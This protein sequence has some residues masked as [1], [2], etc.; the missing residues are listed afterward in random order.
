MAHQIQ[1]TLTPEEAANSEI[2]IPKFAKNAGINVDDIVKFQ[3]TSRSI[4]AR[5]PP[6]KVNMNAKLYTDI[7]DHD[8]II[9]PFAAKDVSKAPEAIIVGAGPAGLFA[10]LTFIEQGIKPVIIERGKRVGER[11]RDVAA[12]STKHY[13][14]PDSNYAFGEGGAGT[15]SDGKLY[16]RSKKRGDI[17]RIYELLYLHGAQEEILYESQPHIGSDVLAQVVVNIRQTI[18]DAGGTILFQQ[19]VTDLIT[20]GEQVTGVKLSD[21]RTMAAAAVVLATGHS[22]RDVYE[23]LQNRG[24]MLEAKGFALGVRLEHPQ[25]LINQIQYHSNEPDPHLPPASYKLVKQVDDRGV[26]SFCMCPGGFIV[27]AATANDQLVVN[28]MSP[29]KRNGTYANSGMVVEL[30]TED[31]PNAEGNPLAGIRYQEQLEKMAFMNGG[32]GQVAPAQG[33]ADFVNNRVSADMPENSYFPGLISSPMHFW[34]PEHVSSRLK[35]AF[36]AFGKKMRGFLTND[37]LVI[38][39]ESRTSSPVRIYRDKEALTSFPYDGLYPTG[40]GAG[41]AGGIVSSALDGVRVARKI[42]ETS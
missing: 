18:L 14:D 42:A 3:I 32:Q 16:T 5:K 33:M 22:A 23:M 24:V 26:Y 25:E 2:Y 29:S 35:I 28:G 9:E 39:L 19:R 27:P 20:E 8:Y 37:A 4:D 36:K 38:G 10:A 21:G 40:E 1:L 15:F 41:Y 34:L 13:V 7:K 31:I 17:R 11:K 6:V 30:R 12:I